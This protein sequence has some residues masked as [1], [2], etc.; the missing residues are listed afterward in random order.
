[1][2]LGGALVAGGIAG[3]MVW[4]YSPAAALMLDLSGTPSRLRAWLPARQDPVTTAD[5]TVPTRRGAIVARIYTPASTASSS[6][7][8]F[9]GI[10]AGDLNEPRLDGFARRLAAAGAIVMSVP[11]PDLRRYRVRPSAT[12]AIEDATAWMA[13]EA[14]LAPRG[15][16]GL[17]GISFAGGLALVAAGRPALDGKLSF[18]VSLGGHGDLPRVMRYLSAVDPPA[19]GAR[20][21]HDYGAVVILLDAIPRLVPADQIP[22]AERALTAFLDASSLESTDRAQSDALFAK[23]AAESASLPEPSRSLIGLVIRRD[24]RAMG[25]LVAPWI[26]ELGGAAALSPVRSPA[27]RAPVFLLH[28]LDDNVIPTSETPLLATFLEGAGN[29]HVRS[30]VTPLLAHAD[31]R[32]DA[33]LGD[34]WRLVRFW[35]A[36]LDAAD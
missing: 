3:W 12:D 2:I 17:V 6:L 8:V 21:P 22:L 5:I 35:S 26:D 34:V 27:T 20:A 28:G 31:A 29:R 24:V 19:P 4:R 14:R 33:P 13:S 1:M 7:I 16:V 11:L 10:H 30:L 15:R 36:I 9:P 23:L 25:A 18:V 32:R